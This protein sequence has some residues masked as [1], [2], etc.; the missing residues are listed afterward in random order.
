MGNFARTF[1][2]NEYIPILALLFKMLSFLLGLLL[3]FF[4]RE[5]NKLAHCLARN[6]LTVLDCVVWMEDVSPQFY[7]IFQAD[8]ASFH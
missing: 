5:G 1:C 8:V 3:N 7:S 6:S 2:R 4:T